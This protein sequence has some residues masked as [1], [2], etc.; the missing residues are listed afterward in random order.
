M[1]NFIKK[2]DC[3]NSF[4]F[5]LVQVEYVVRTRSNKCYFVSL[6]NSTRLSSARSLALHVRAISTRAW[7]LVLQIKSTRVYS[8]AL[9]A[10][11]PPLP[12]EQPSSLKG[13]CCL[14]IFNFLRAYLD[15]PPL[16]S[17]AQPG[18]PACSCYQH[19]RGNYSYF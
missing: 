3:P 2:G 4:H 9:M 13:T 8:A 11:F 17:A 16:S 10:C 1:D 6:P 12:K 14:L 15:V 19:C 18:P 7:Q 5:A